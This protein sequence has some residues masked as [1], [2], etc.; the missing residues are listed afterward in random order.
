MPADYDAVLQAL[1]AERRPGRRFLEWGS[2]NGVIAIMAD[3]LGFE[4]SGIELDDRLVTM[5]RALAAKYNS[6]ARFVT[7]SFLPTGY[8]WHPPDGD[9]RTGTIGDGASGYLA[10]GHALDEFDLVFAFPWG[11]EEPM[12][13]DV[14]RAYGDPAATLLLNTVSGRVRVYHG[15]RLE[16]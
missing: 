5:A 8:A 12:M 15:S 3:L 7:G 1:L 9:G 14:M 6:N 2:A 13:V 16:S 10:L 4:A 11:G